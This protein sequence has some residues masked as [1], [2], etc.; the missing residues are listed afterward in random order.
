MQSVK[1][2]QTIHRLA[3]E[4]QVAIDQVEARARDILQDMGGSI[5]TA[6]VRFE[7]YLFRKVYRHLYNGVLIDEVGIRKLTEASRNGPVI[8]LPTHRSYMDFLLTSYV[9]FYHKL[10][11]PLIAAGDDFLSMMFVRWIF[12]NSEAFFIRRSFGSINYT[13]HLSRVCVC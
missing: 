10:P 5:S 4:E 3:S 7:A 9:C 8:L 12:R 13:I 2:Q 6:V 11:L 1:V